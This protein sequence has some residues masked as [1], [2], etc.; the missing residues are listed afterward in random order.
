MIGTIFLFG[1]EVV[2]VRVDGNNV[3][4]R[5]TGGIFATIEGLKLDKSGVLKEHPD[6][7]NNDDWQ[8]IARERFNEKI[9]TFNTEKEK[10]NYIIEDLEKFGYVAKYQQRQGFRVV[11]LK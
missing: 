5:N 6:L 1:S 11:R 9:K 7:E 3:F 4:F 2:E 10:M 8:K